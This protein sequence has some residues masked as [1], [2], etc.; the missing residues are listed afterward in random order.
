[1]PNITIKVSNT[2]D[3]KA[4]LADAIELEK[5]A[6]LHGLI[7]TEKNVKRLLKALNVRA[8]EI[9]KAERTEENE[10]EFIELEGELGIL[11]RL[12]DKKE[13]LDS[14]VICD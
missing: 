6:I 3:S 11:A 9:E 10:L 12:K 13:K 2:P 8:S 4:L 5:K 1:M 7:K 14:M